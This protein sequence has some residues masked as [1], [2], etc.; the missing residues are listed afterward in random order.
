MSIWNK[1][2]RQVY[3]ILRRG[4][5]N[6]HA[7]KKET[8]AQCWDVLD[9]YISHWSQDLCILQLHFS[10]VQRGSGG[11]QGKKKEEK[12]REPLLALTHCTL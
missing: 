8:G 10:P 2:C 4:H 12:E 5:A 11:T 7:G 6:G 9:T 1:S 3:M